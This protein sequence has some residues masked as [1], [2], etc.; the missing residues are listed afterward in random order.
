[1]NHNLSKK[2]LIVDDELEIVQTIKMFL[3]ISG[4][5]H[6]YDAC[7]GKEALEIIKS[8]E[9]DLVISDV[10]MPDMDGISFAKAAKELFPEK[11]IFLMITGQSE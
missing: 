8:E 9:I 1:M 7:S 2:I 3:E 10:R 5:E 6:I 11:I 4:Y